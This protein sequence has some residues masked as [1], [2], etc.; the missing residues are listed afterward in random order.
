MSVRNQLNNDITSICQKPST[1]R[2]PRHF[3]APY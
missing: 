3:D 1:N 2:S